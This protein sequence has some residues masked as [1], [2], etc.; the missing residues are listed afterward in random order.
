MCSPALLPTRAPESVFGSSIL[1]LAMEL[2]VCVLIDSRDPLFS[3]CKLASNDC[4]RWT[5]VR[6]VCM[7]ELRNIT[8]ESNRIASSID[9]EGKIRVRCIR[10]APR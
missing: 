7:V 2:C 9:Q 1:G 8:C 4:F 6:T 3:L 5:S 10:M